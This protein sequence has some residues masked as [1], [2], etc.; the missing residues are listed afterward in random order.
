MLDN[1]RLRDTLSE[2]VIG[3][4]FPQRR[5]F[6]ERVTLLPYTYIACLVH[7]ATRLFLVS[8]KV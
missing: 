3:I 1:L 2:D 8:G 5:W 6:C 4:V 7:Y